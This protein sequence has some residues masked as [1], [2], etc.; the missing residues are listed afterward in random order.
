MMAARTNNRVTL[1]QLMD[2]LAEA[3]A[4]DID[5]LAIDS[6]E[7]HGRCLFIAVSG[8]TT[9]GIEHVADALARGA[10]AVATDLP[11]TDLRVQA[12]QGQIPVVCIGDDRHVPALLASRLYAAPSESLSLVAITGTNGKSSVAWLVASALHGLAHDSAVMGTLGSGRIDALLN[13]TLTTPDAISVQR[14]LRELADDGVT[15]LALEASSHALSQSRLAHV[16]IDIAVFSNLSRDHLDYHGTMDA[17]FEAKA[18]LFVLPSLTARIIAT[19]DTY[20]LTLWQRYATEAIRVSTAPLDSLPAHYVFV[21]EQTLT[22]DGIRL[23][24]NSHLGSATIDAPLIGQFNVQN[25]AL[26]FAVLLARGFAPTEAARALSVVNAPPGRMQRIADSQLA[27][28]VDYSHTPD[29]LEQALLSL[30]PHTAGRLFCVFGCGGERDR[31]K[32]AL[33]AAIAER[34][35]DV[36]VL[37]SDNPRSESIERILDDMSAGLRGSSAI[38]EPDRRAAIRSAIGEA[39]V[40]DVVLIAG[41]GHERFQTIGGQSLPFDDAA[42]ARLALRARAEEDV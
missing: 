38:I 40:D 24:L 4:V 20:G 5:S 41:K 14:R 30:R 10:V 27:V 31:G 6:R 32:R 37:T 23:T 12:L 7:V 29:A 2:G 22:I 36:P 26:A 17:Y 34:I 8:L 35:A 16:D 25:L 11:A 9:H 15:D 1:A 42:E 18:A 28:F 19:D 33:M 39:S 21:S 13:Q 3:P